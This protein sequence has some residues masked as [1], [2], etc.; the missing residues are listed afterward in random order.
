MAALLRSRSQRRA[1]AVR[2]GKPIRNVINIG[3][4]GSDLGPAMAYEALALLQPARPDV[5]LRLERRRPPTW[6]RRPAISIPPRPSSIV[7]SKT[8]TTDR[9][10][11]ERARAPSLDRRRARRGGRARPRRRRVDEPRGGR[12]SSGSIPTNA[13]GFWDWVGGRYS[14]GWRDRP[15][16]DA[17][18]RAGAV[19]ASCSPASTRPTSTSPARRS[20]RTSPALMGLLAVWY[21]GC[22][23]FQTHAVLPVRPLPPAVPRVPPAALDGVERQVGH[24]RRRAGR[25]RHRR[26]HLGRARDERPAQL[27]PAAPSG[28][29]GRAVRPDRRSRRRSTRSAS[30]TTC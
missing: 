14:M 2:P 12:A 26:G 5:P 20:R 22:F 11:D 27:P 28:N 18:G 9:D 29:D 7:S 4:G 6:S 1:G 13:F 17:G 24:P 16:D 10:D 25:D 19:R 30:S 15:V 3:I 23:G 21:R 8:F